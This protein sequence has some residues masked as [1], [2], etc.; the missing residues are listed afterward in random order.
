MIPIRR[1]L[2]VIGLY[3]VSAL[4]ISVVAGISWF[5]EWL[6]RPVISSFVFWCILVLTILMLAAIVG[7]ALYHRQVNKTDTQ[8][9]KETKRRSYKQL[10]QA[11]KRLTAKNNWRSMRV[12]WLLFLGERNEQNEAQLAALGF[13]QVANDASDSIEGFD[14]WA[15]QSAILFFVSPAVEDLTSPIAAS[16]KDA[17]LEA[18]ES[19]AASPQSTEAST[20]IDVAT[21]IAEFL[22]TLVTVRNRKPINAI[23]LGI[24]FSTILPGHEPKPLL[25]SEDRARQ[26]LNQVNLVL[27]YRPPCYGLITGLDH[28]ADISQL[29]AM[30]TASRDQKPFGVLLKSGNDQLEDK[31]SEAFQ[32][33]HREICKAQLDLIADLH[34]P[35]AVSHILRAPL[36]LSVVEKILIAF[37]NDLIA[38]IPP[39]RRPIDLQ[40][41]FFI[42]TKVEGKTLTPVSDMIEGLYTDQSG[43][44]QV[45]GNATMI[46]GPA[47][48]LY[49]DVLFPEC[50]MGP[51]NN[52]GNTRYWL[53]TWTVSFIFLTVTAIIGF[54][55]WFNINQY[56]KLNAN[57]QAVY[58]NYLEKSGEISS[59]TA[60]ISTNVYAIDEL[61]KELDEFRQARTTTEWRFWPRPSLER[62]YQSEYHRA[63]LGNFRDSL[64]KFLS[65]EIDVSRSFSSSVE[66][67]SLY[68]T[69]Q[70]FYT[71]QAWNSAKL[72]NYFQTGLREQ[73]EISPD[74]QLRFRAN[75]Q[76]LFALNMPPKANEEQQKEV[77][78]QLQSTE[79]LAR[80]LYLKA[81]SDE[82]LTTKIDI[83]DLIS[84]DFHNVFAGPDNT[85]EFQV[86]YAFTLDGFIELFG[87]NEKL[88]S[89]DVIK[90]FEEAIGDLFT[91]SRVN[92]I[93][94]QMIQLYIDDYSN[95]W[96]NLQKQLV[97]RELEDWEIAQ[98]TLDSLTRGETPMLQ[99]TYELFRDNTSLEFVLRQN[100]QSGGDKAEPEENNSNS[101]TQEAKS[102][103]KEP[104]A[105][106][107]QTVGESENFSETGYEIASSIQER[108]SE[109]R[110]ALDVKSDGKSWLNKFTNEIRDVA[111]WMEEANLL[112]DRGLYLFDQLT[113]DPSNDVLLQLQRTANLQK[114]GPVNN[115]AFVIARQVNSLSVQ[116]INDFVN[117]RWWT[118]VYR[119]LKSGVLTKFPFSPDAFEEV[120]Y[121][122]FKLAF[123]PE[124]GF[125]ETFMKD[126]I[127]PLSL[128]SGRESE[129]RTFLPG[130]R[131]GLNPDLARVVRR[132]EMISSAFFAEDQLKIDFDIRSSQLPA[133]FYEL[134]VSS[135]T[136]I[137]RYQHGPQYWSSISFPATSSKSNL[138]QFEL[139]QRGANTK[140]I[141]FNGLW[142]WFR[143]AKAL[144]ASENTALDVVEFV[145]TSPYG[146]TVFQVRS[147]TVYNPFVNDYFTNFYLP[148][149]A[150]HE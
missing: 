77:R 54:G 138:L 115:I 98:Q 132:S 9:K 56:R 44:I 124:T 144:D 103:P 126:Y 23:Y 100:E 94:R 10:A 22:D 63:L 111:D 147:N 121:Q 37:F 90:E 62:F 47:P 16:S 70:Q 150:L 84:S 89:T 74:F 38:P 141:S 140:T 122:D 40:G 86:P 18:V 96:I 2:L 136:T 139:F 87:N 71:D 49:N 81:L 34:D 17:K 19:S 112:G 102:T 59:E 119:P 6:P 78:N 149:I 101:P 60:L 69:Q 137:F 7:L 29:V 91:S 73:G 85:S 58:L 36:Q 93:N 104:K 61:R 50:Y 64:A 106:S 21:E 133:E 32:G 134:R 57:A 110:V 14:L 65:L 128:D 142:T 129:I 130:E 117:D 11:A 146:P 39:L 108:F 75:L 120:S 27:G 114:L 53:S 123:A 125:V 24:E 28:L 30:S 76:R 13:F 95:Y 26:C 3:L 46:D 35:E 8:R 51:F 42:R 25:W 80:L 99:A 92:Q 113:K 118:D 116:D 52:A 131:G 148:T 43:R 79:K 82:Q 67:L 83:R 107:V 127:Y 45:R 143:A 135:D 1:F 109:F 105:Q 4:L 88:F 5:F 41:L 97:L 20:Y 72:V 55:F 31:I 15:S 48:Q 145:I 12:P 66:L 33:L 68:Q